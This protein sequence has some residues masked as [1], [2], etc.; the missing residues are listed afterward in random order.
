MPP[1]TETAASPGW[2]GWPVPPGS[3]RQRGS[4]TTP[5]SMRSRLVKN[6]L[7]VG[8][9]RTYMVIPPRR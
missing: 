5:G 2:A 4:D 8:R 6:R 7:T 9:K 1:Y 3:V